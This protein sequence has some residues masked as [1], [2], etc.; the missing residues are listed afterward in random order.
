M[1]VQHTVALLHYARW[2]WALWFC[3]VLFLLSASFVQS[4]YDLW[5][6][7]EWGWMLM[8][9]FVDFSAVVTSYERAEILDAWAQHSL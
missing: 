1:R 5:D 6:G 9:K 8:L 4:E 3:V 2:Q 7:V